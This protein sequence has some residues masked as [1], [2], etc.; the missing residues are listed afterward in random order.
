MNLFSVWKLLILGFFSNFL[1]C[2]EME[3]TNLKSHWI[4]QGVSFIYP[5]HAK[6]LSNRL[7]NQVGYLTS[8]NI[9]PAGN[10]WELR[11]NL[12]L[13][14]TNY[15]EVSEEE[16]N[17]GLGVFLTKNNPRKTQ[18]T[19]NYSTAS[20]IFGMVPEI[21]GLSLLFSKNNLY[22][23]LFKS[24]MMTKKD[25][26]NRSKICKA[27]LQK[28][29]KIT[30][31]IK[32]R[33]KILGVYIAEEKEKFEH[34][35]YQFTDIEDFTEFYFSV[36]G[37]DKQS[38]CA[39][40]L[41]DLKINSDFEGYQI[42]N[43]DQKKTDEPTFS[44]FSDDQN[45]RKRRELE[46]FHTVYD[47]YR[48]NAKIFA[49]ELLTFADFNEKEVVNEMKSTI[50]QT[51]K[52]IEEAITI[53][54]LEAKQIEALN[55]LLNSERRSV[56]ADVNETLDQ[57]LK[58]LQ[59]MDNMFDKVDSE[60]QSIHG[61]LSGL[62]YDEKLDNLLLKVELVGNNLSRAISKTK[63]IVKPSKL[64]DL[65]E[66]ELSNWKSQINGFQSA[67]NEQI[68][69]QG[70]QKLSKLQILGFTILGGIAIAIFLAF[71]VMYCKI[72]TAMR[73]KRML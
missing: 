3:L 65:D 18:F 53:V 30:L 48:D 11:A 14:C 57:I 26:L 56:N 23:G 61:I 43:N 52:S 31:S 5:R 25:I 49:K 4:G 64:S 34:L 46:H 9:F 6:I 54:E 71:L 62:N 36:S 28:T 70:G 33:S 41:Y 21:E 69:F 8:Y 63:M 59:T 13:K 24:T 35:C 68:A 38:R 12:Q 44:Y 58:W 55:N 32:Y 15:N 29:G 66:N 51:E 45:S 72:R 37:S 67:V 22:A 17:V 73:N 2:T 39:A 60:T 27:Y 42:V 1:L 10:Q 50:K 47:F 19:Y 7:E 40:D 20:D 16:N